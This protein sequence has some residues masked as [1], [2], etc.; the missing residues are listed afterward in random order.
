[1]G[2]LP[3]NGGDLSAPSEQ[4]AAWLLNSLA[5][6]GAVTETPPGDCLLTAGALILVALAAASSTLALDAGLRAEGISDLAS[7]EAA[8]WRCRAR[9]TPTSATLT[10]VPSPFDSPLLE[11]VGLRPQV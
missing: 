11:A 8:V 7:L 6:S 9:G 2:G 5:P 1:M 3:W 10:R 4:A